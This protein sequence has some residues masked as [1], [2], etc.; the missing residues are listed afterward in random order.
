MSIDPNGLAQPGKVYT[1]HV[2]AALTYSGDQGAC[3]DPNNGEMLEKITE[4]AY[5]SFYFYVLGL[6]GK[7]YIN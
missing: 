6:Y 4:N 7:V 3:T 2:I 5:T 1:A